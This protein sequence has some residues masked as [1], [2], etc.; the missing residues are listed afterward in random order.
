MVNETKVLDIHKEK[1]PKADTERTRE[2]PCFIPRSDIYEVDDKIVLLLDMPG[3]N[4]N[5]INITLDKSVL[6]VNGYVRVDEPEG[7]SLMHAEYE[8]GDYER[9]FRISNQI[10]Q[11]NIDAIYNNGTLKLILPK[12]ESAMPQRIKVKVGE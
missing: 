2:C 1:L 5:A 7:Y 9:S 8:T 11:S 4:P 12:S 10:D 3:V 6:T